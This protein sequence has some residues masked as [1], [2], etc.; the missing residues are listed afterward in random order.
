MINEMISWHKMFSSNKIILI[1]SGPLSTEGVGKIAGSVKQHLELDDMP[2]HVSQKVISVFVE[3]MNNMLMYSAEITPIETADKKNTE[4]PNGTFILGKDENNYF[5]QTGNVIN[6][7]S[8]EFV[9]SK[10]NFL[11][12]L[13]ED[14]LHKYYR[15]QM[16]GSNNNPLSRGAG[17]G[18]IEIARRTNSKIEYSFLPFDEGHTFF[19][20]YVTIGGGDG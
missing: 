17:L 6:N 19:I 11:N 14:E 4:F 2:L 5:I 20:L 18:F 16:K 3:Q 8:I 10:I 12:S 15:E 13:D 7:E 1:Y 9:K